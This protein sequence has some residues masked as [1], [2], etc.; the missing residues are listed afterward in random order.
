ML[1]TYKSNLYDQSISCIGYTSLIPLAKSVV[2]ATSLL[3]MM[4]SRNFFQVLGEILRIHLLLKS[5]G[6]LL[7]AYVLYFDEFLLFGYASV[8][9][10]ILQSIHVCSVTF[11]NYLRL[12]GF[13]YLHRDCGLVMI[14]FWK[15]GI[16]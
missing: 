2:F 7:R 4:C 13:F 12:S 9:Q 1:K 16:R 3:H 5:W 11:H 6:L 15:P 8:L 14:A 10:T